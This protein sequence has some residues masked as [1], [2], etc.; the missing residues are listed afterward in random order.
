MINAMCVQ[1]HVT[2][3]MECHA[4]AQYSRWYICDETNLME[5]RALFDIQKKI[6]YTR[7]DLLKKNVFFV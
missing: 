3:V 5:N 2:I 7:T 4:K 1:S 6:C